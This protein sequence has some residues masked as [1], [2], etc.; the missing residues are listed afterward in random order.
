MTDQV[1]SVVSVQ[2][3]ETRGAE[4]KLPQVCVYFACLV[5]AHFYRKAWER[6]GHRKCLPQSGWG[7]GK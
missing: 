1:T 4:I 3:S 2:L 5:S 7:S 6:L